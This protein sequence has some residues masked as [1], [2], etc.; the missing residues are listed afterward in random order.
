MFSSFKLAIA[1]GSTGIDFLSGYDLSEVDYAAPT[2]QVYADAHA[3]GCKPIHPSAIKF[4]TPWNGYQYWCA[5]TPFNQAGEIQ[6]ENPCIACSEDGKVWAD[7][8]VGLNPLDPWPG[9]GEW[10]SDTFL[11]Y[12]E[13]SLQVWWRHQVGDEREKFWRRT[14]TDG[15]TWTAA[16]LCWDNPTGT[17][18]LPTGYGAASPNILPL[19]GGGWQLWGV[20]YNR[21]TP[22]TLRRWTAPALTGPWTGATLCTVNGM[23]EGDTI[24]HMTIRWIKGKY[25]MLGSITTEGGGTYFFESNDGLT[26][27]RAESALVTDI[28][29]GTVGQGL[30]Y[31][32]D[33]LLDGTGAEPEFEVILASSKAWN[34]ARAA[35]FPTGA[36][37]LLN[38]V[39]LTGD[40]IVGD[41]FIRADAATPGTTTS[42]TPWVV[43]GSSAFDIVSNRLKAHALFNNKMVIDVGTPN[44][45]VGM[46]LAF[47]PAAAQEFYLMARSNADGSQFFRYGRN[48]SGLM[49][50]TKLTPTSEAIVTTNLPSPVPGDWIALECLGDQISIYLN[51]TKFGSWTDTHQ[52][53]STRHG[54]NSA[55]VDTLIDGFFIEAL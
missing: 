9:A 10:N 38:A 34:M 26:W 4:D 47:V 37:R 20:T 15:V 53:T 51:N 44:V 5:Y 45:R 35:K 1:G 8:A 14:S 17:Q 27:T 21:G 46:R 39:A 40:Y 29:V 18:A 48:G 32:C 23:D 11:L 22:N 19:P 30:G 52:Q 31:K 13:G 43:L 16:E 12:A 33:F 42:G 3:A 50:L 25:V 2:Y 6:Y 49:A 7:P 36:Q 28:R 55:S 24:W 54:I 41:D